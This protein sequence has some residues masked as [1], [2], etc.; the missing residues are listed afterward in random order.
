MRVGKCRVPACATA[1]TTSTDK[2]PASACIGP[3][4]SR[5]LGSAEQAGIDIPGSSSPVISMSADGCPV[6][7]AVASTSFLSSHPSLP[8]PLS[9]NF[10]IISSG[11]CFRISA[12]KS[13]VLALKEPLRPLKELHSSPRSRSRISHLEK[14]EGLEGEDGRCVLGED[15]KD[16]SRLAGKNDASERMN[17]SSGGQGSALPWKWYCIQ[18]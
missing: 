17:A 18:E 5:R 1:G 16:R 12:F 7:V 9:I 14:F 13:I 4:V 10:R 3:L 6:V 8:L 11:F 15:V 2:A